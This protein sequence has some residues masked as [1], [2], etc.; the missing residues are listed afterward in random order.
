MNRR[1]SGTVLVSLATLLTPSRSLARAPDV[2]AEASD[3]GDASQ[4]IE[5][6]ITL[7]KAGDDVRAL[8]LFRRAERVEPNST[9]VQVHLAATY[10]ALGDWEAADRYITLA[11]QNPNDPY[12]Q[13]HQA[14][15]ASARRTI[16]SHMGSLQLSGGP[17][18]TEI[19]LNGRLI[20]TLPIRETVRVQA[21]I[22]ALEARLPGHYPITRS[23]ALAG[24]SLAR[25][26][27]ELSPLSEQA[28]AS[29][30]VDSGPEETRQATWLTWTF[31]GLAAGAGVGTVAAMVTRERHVDAYND[32][33]DC[34]L[35]EQTREEACGGER[36]AGDRAEKWMWIGAA[37]TGAFAA[38]SLVSYWLSE[39][40]EEPATALRC[41][42]GLAQ[43]A[44]AGRF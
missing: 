19:R 5:R 3:V 9:R 10:Q 40:D 31:A 7:R 30:P 29:R 43:V 26:S 35:V 8:D 39:P 4:L 13:K 37:G 25:E 32:D 15:L 6:G 34:W 21:G 38:A 42:V 28:G 11:L 17:A 1:V 18:G 44:C 27:I 23:I 16:D 41:G 33:N 2:T 20:G 12:V 36:K 24:G 14:I 22:Y